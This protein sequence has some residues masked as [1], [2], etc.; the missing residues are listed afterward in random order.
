MRLNSGLAWSVV[1][2][3]CFLYCTEG[4]GV[5]HEVTDDLTEDTDLHLDV[6][7]EGIY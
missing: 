4:L 7:E 6:P 2:E 1:Y 3:F 5:N